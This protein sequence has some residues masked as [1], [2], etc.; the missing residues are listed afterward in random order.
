[1]RIAICGAANTGKTTLV[2]GFLKKWKTYSTPK[3]TYRDLIKEGAL[4]HSTCTTTE[5]QTKILASLIKQQ[6][7]FKRLDK[8]IIHDRCTIDAL[9]YTMWCY[10]KNKDGFDTTYVETQIEQV[11]ESMRSLDIIF[12]AKFDKSQVPEDNGVR[13]TDVEYITE[14]DNIYESLYQQ[15][16]QNAAADVFFPKDDTPLILPL[17]HN[18]QARISMIADYITPEGEMYGEENS[19]L[20]PENIGELEHLVHQQQ[21]EREAEEA[22]KELLEK[23]N[24]EL[25][26]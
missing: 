12:L 22:E 4:D 8:K 21:L 24:K 6:E 9:A 17:P 26:L 25:N 3:N 23:V 14:I 15:Y 18:E 11:K 2:Q 20:N 1:M 13:E 19:I 16:K 5:N 10:G 7:K